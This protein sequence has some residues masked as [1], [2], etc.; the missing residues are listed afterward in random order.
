MKDQLFLLKPGFHNVG[1]GPLY[2]T[3]SL[4]IEGMLSFFPQLRELLDIRYL[5]FPRPRTALVELLGEKHQDIPVLVIA[6]GRK[7]QAE[8]PE[9]ALIKR[10]RILTQE[11]QIRLYLSAQYGLPHAG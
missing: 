9:P 3:E 1:L 7:L 11:G 8:A 10:H 2:C 4:P 6:A 5:D